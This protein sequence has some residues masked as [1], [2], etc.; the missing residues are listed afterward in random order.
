MAATQ[1]QA[2]VAS[3]SGTE[4]AS[5]SDAGYETDSLQSSSTSISSSVRHYL[6][7]NG[8]RYHKFR[9]GSYNF[10]NDES[11]Q[12]REIMKHLMMSELCQ[13]LYF[14]PLG[15]NPGEV[16]DLGTGTGAW[17]IDSESFIFDLGSPA[18][19]GWG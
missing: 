5:E 9:E 4:G 1:A 18:L 3:G 14:A 7:E 17:A 19:R 12:E 2:S 10:P 15:E 11:E 13:T 16:L 8:R 6:F